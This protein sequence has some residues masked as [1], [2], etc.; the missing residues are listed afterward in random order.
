MWLIDIVAGKS[1]ESGGGIREFLVLNSFLLIIFL[2]GTMPTIV[3][4]VQT[5]QIFRIFYGI[6][7][8]LLINS[9]IFCRWYNG[10]K[11]AGF[12]GSYYY[13]GVLYDYN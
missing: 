9:Q 7:V 4:S 1:I 2:V 6:T 13:G 10:I 12:I 8:I 3:I 5:Q 11:Y